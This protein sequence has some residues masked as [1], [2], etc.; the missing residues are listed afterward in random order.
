MYILNGYHMSIK[1]FCLKMCAYVSPNQ[2]SHMTLGVHLV[3][4]SCHAKK[5]VAWT[6]ASLVEKRCPLLIFILLWH[7]GTN[8]STLVSGG[9]LW[10]SPRWA[11]WI[12]SGPILWTPSPMN[13]SVVI[14]PRE[15]ALEQSHTSSICR[16]LA[17]GTLIHEHLKTPH[18]LQNYAKLDSR[19]QDLILLHWWLQKSCDG[20]M[21]S[22]AKFRDWEHHCP[23]CTAPDTRWQKQWLAPSYNIG[24]HNTQSKVRT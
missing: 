3:M 8:F 17:I 1:R 24:R 5:H 6:P 10:P 19:N 14:T 16:L 11:P 20:S 4:A 13:C 21:G 22:S 18:L 7:Y 23:A 12:R 15:V 2:K 9:W